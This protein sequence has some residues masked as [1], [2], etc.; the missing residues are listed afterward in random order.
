MAAER[1]LESF[2][3]HSAFSILPKVRT[4]DN[5]STPNE[6][7][8]AENALRTSWRRRINLASGK[9]YYRSSER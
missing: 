3:D 1:D 9:S 2:V 4:L 8:F 6:T 5:D 7:V